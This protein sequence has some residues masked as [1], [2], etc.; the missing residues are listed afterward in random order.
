[1]G[2]VND[3][4]D[5]HVIRL[6]RV[7]DQMGLKAE[8]SITRRQFVNGRTDAREIGK[9]AEGANEAGIVGIGLV[10]AESALSEVVDVDKSFRARSVSRNSAMVTRGNS[11]PGS[12]ENVVGRVRRE[13][14]AIRMPEHL[15]I[16]T[17]L[18][19]PGKTSPGIE[20]GFGR[21]RR[22]HHAGR[23]VGRL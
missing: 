11:L 16:A 23:F 4:T 8:T 1:L 7:E 10:R 14:V 2:A 5:F 3:G 9:K 21:R 22:R 13:R 6:H 19:V 18:L 20:F 17:H 15:L 12:G